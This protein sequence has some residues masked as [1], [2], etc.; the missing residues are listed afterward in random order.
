MLWGEATNIYYI[1]FGLNQLRLKCTINCTSGRRAIY[2]INDT[3]QESWVVTT[4]AT[5]GAGIAYP[6][7]GVHPQR[8]VLLTL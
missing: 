1:F 5:S 3:V 6:S 7:E 4:D 8:F 2:Y